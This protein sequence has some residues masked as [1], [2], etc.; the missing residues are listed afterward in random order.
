M[1][2]TTLAPPVATLTLNRPG[3]RNALSPDLLGQ[4]IETADAL[5]TDDSVHV[6]VLRGAG[7]LFSAGA[8]L[9]AFAP[10]LAHEGRPAADLGRRALEALDRL[11]QITVSWVHGPC[12]GGG[13]VL[14]AAC[15]LR[16]ASPRARFWLPEVEAGIPVA[17]GGL[18]PLYRV[19][20]EAMLT[21]LV[22]L[23]RRLDA[24]EA[25]QA[26]F[27]HRIVERPDREVS[28][29]ATR[30]GSTLRATRQQL[31]DL[32]LQRFDPGADADRLLAA[33]RDP[34][35][36]AAMQAYLAERLG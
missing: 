35:V 24:Q 26:G 27:V 4:L 3:A 33:M 18:A 11:P 17:W 32:R 28:T 10:A 13:M 22:L 34:E 31:Q 21:E 1:L 12:V 36:I 8:D 30:P 14:A 15:D 2:D 25:L 16:L 6:V 19:L 29:L 20:G 7:E 5:A 23:D 9:L